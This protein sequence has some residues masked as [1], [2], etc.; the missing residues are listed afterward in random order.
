MAK[1]IASSSQQRC[2]PLQSIGHLGRRDG[3][4]GRMDSWCSGFQRRVGGQNEVLNGIARIAGTK[5]PHASHEARYRAACKHRM[6]WRTTGCAGFKL[7]LLLPSV[8]FCRAPGMLGRSLS[9]RPCQTRAPTARCMALLNYVILSDMV[10]LTGHDGSYRTCGGRIACP[11]RQGLLQ[12][13]L[14]LRP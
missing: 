10:Y 6:V 3:F 5:F 2:N 8:S 13:M 7:K 11:L 14:R 1:M 12:G 9:G 4:V